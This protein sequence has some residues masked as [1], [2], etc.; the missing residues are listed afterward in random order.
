MLVFLL[1]SREPDLVSL[2]CSC[3]TESCTPDFAESS[4]IPVIWFQLM[5]ELLNSA[6]GIESANVPRS[7]G[8]ALC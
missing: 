4:D 1:I 7:Y 3:F 5:G 8:N 2:L 6:S